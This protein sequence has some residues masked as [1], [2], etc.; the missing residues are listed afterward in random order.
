MYV[1]SIGHDLGNA[2]GCGGHVVDL[3][4]RKAGPFR[5]EDGVSPEAFTAAVE[6]GT[7]RELI[8]T[9]DTVVQNLP[10]ATVTVALEAFVKNGRA[11][12]LGPR[13]GLEQVHHGDLCRIYTH[14][15]QFLAL[16]RFDKPLGQWKPEK[17]FDP[18]SPFRQKDHALS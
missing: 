13:E 6:R 3:Q 10:A 15:G 5:I 9:P 4:R 16:A 2:L 8:H 14:D 1:R 17:V 11:V 18:R 7:W 12:R